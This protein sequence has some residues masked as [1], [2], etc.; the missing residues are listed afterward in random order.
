M[1]LTFSR[2]GASILVAA[3][4]STLASA[5]VSSSSATAKP[6][7]PQQHR[8]DEP[9]RRENF[10]ETTAKHAWLYC[11]LIV[12]LQLRGSGTAS[13]VAGYGAVRCRTAPYRCERTRFVNVGPRRSLYRGKAAYSY[14]TFPP[15]IC[16]SVCLF[17]CLSSALWQNG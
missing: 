1:A 3:A 15:T 14:R 10:R 13:C 12:L 7:T 11:K 16:S 6:Y 9:Q 8:C 17:V 4:S 2:N 5:A